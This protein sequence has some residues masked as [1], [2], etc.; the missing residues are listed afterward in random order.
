MCVCVCVCVC[1]CACAVFMADPITDMTSMTPARG[2]R[3]QKET[4]K[5]TLSLGGERRARGR[6]EEGWGR[7]EEDWGRGEEG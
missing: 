2:S 1:V 5:V 7:R 4:G 6:G 3:V